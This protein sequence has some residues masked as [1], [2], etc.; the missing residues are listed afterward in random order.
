MYCK[1]RSLLYNT[2]LLYKLSELEKCFKEYMALLSS[3]TDSTNN[4]DYNHHIQK[5]IEII[6]LLKQII[7]EINISK[8]LPAYLLQLKI[9]RSYG[10]TGRPIKN[11]PSSGALK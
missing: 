2:Y 7:E 6:E 8:F 1:E 4:F 3:T 11:F 5:Q 9:Q 10:W